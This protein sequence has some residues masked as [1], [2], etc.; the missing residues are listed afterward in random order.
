MTNWRNHPQWRRVGRAIRST[1]IPTT[2]KHRVGSGGRDQASYD[3]L[4][5]QFRAGAIYSFGYDGDEWFTWATQADYDATDRSAK[6]GSLADQAARGGAGPRRFGRVTVAKAKR[7]TKAEAVR[8]L[9]AIH[10]GT[11]WTVEQIEDLLAREAA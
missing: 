8:L 9:R 5:R 3:E 10:E 7:A 2:I 1:V 6:A 4:S 11:D